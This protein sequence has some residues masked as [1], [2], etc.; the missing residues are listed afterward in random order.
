MWFKIQSGDI[1]ANSDMVLFATLT[2]VPLIGNF[3]VNTAN[4]F[5]NTANSLMSHQSGFFGVSWGTFS[6]AMG[7]PLQ[8]GEVVLPELTVG[9]RN[10]PLTLDAKKFAANHTRNV[11]G[12]PFQEGFAQIVFRGGPDGEEPLL[13]RLIPG[14]EG[15][16]GATVICPGV[17]LS[18]L[19]NQILNCYT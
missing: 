7:H 12:C 11:G 16:P 4:P 8:D 18:N 15:N 14:A 3:F 10:G 2:E 19:L 9:P 1:M 17:L 13:N 5:E 6:T